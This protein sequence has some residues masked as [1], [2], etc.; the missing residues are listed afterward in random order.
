MLIW[1]YG[2][3][4]LPESLPSENRRAFSWRRS[5]PVGSLLALRRYPVVFGLAGTYFLIML[6]HQALPSTW[7]LYTGYRY[8]WTTTEVGVSLAIVGL[9]SAIVQGGLEIGRASC[10][11]SV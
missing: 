8:G 9:M 4:V 5:N 2:M 1:V 3:F 6:A 7:V 10:R 11:E